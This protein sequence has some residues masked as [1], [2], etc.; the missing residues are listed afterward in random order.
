VSRPRL[1]PVSPSASLLPCSAGS[2]RL[3]GSVCRS[4]EPLGRG[5]V[6]VPLEPQHAGAGGGAAAGAGPA[7][8]GAAHAG[9]PREGGQHQPHEELQ[10]HAQEGQPH[11]GRMRSRHG[12]EYSMPG[13]SRSNRLSVRLSKNVG[14][15]L[16]GRS[17]AAARLEW[18]S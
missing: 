13:G 8:G 7:R 3:P 18:R 14:R 12:N 9:L 6:H 17:F 2:L 15:L 4:A 5:H 16:L 1:F 11:R 10:L